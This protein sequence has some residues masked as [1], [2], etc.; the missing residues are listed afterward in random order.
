M[1]RTGQYDIVS[2]GTD[3]EGKYIDLGDAAPFEGV[4]VDEAEGTVTFHGDSDSEVQQALRRLMSIERDRLL[5][6]P[7]SELHMDPQ[8]AL[9]DAVDILRKRGKDVD[10]LIFPDDQEKLGIE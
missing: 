9:Q 8:D 1:T 7:R 2:T 6:Y 5:G 3:A 10:G 4:T